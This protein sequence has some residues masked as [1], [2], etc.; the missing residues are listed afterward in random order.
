MEILPNDVYFNTFDASTARFL[1]TLVTMDPSDLN[2]SADAQQEHPASIRDAY[3][4][5]EFEE[6]DELESDELELFLTQDRFRIDGLARLEAFKSKRAKDQLLFEQEE[7]R[8]RR[9]F[10]AKQKADVDFFG[11]EEDRI[12]TELEQQFMVKVKVSLK[13]LCVSCRN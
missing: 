10:E 9:E 7:A 13:H 6:I 8:R 12:Q 3:D 1:N 5:E 2:R 4:D 11:N